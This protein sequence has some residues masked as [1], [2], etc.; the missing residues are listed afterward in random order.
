MLHGMAKQKQHISS[1]K[2]FLWDK[3]PELGLLNQKVDTFIILTEIAKLPPLESNL[4]S[5]QQCICS[6]VCVLF[7]FI[8][9]HRV[10]VVAPRIFIASCGIFPCGAQTLQ[11]WCAGLVVAG[12][13]A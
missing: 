2:L 4:C 3:V 5:H 8:W 1:A 9:L 11:L 13:W 10:L 7:L 6:E 12:T